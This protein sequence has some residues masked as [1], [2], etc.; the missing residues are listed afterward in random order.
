MKNMTKDIFLNSL[1][2]PMLGWIL[3]SE[4]YIEGLS[5]QSLTLA[6]RFR[7]EQ[8]IEIENRA[9]QLFPN[10]ILVDEKRM[11]LAHETTRE[12]MDAPD[13]SVIFNGAFLSEGF[14]TRTDVLRRKDKGW[15]LIEIKSSVNDREEFIDDIA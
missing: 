8:G 13:T 10:G 11:P 14:S 7:I 1:V 5:D 12:L 15:Q 6:E 4:E 2:C 3:R 9:R